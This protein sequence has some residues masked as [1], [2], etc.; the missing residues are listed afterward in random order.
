VPVARAQRAESAIRWTLRGRRFV[1]DQTQ[2]EAQKPLGETGGDDDCQGEYGSEDDDFHF[3][4]MY[5]Q[6][7]K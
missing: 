3:T 7:V 1:G 5:R 6:R 2:D 4:P